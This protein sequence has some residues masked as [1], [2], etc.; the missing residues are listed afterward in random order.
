[1]IGHVSIPEAIQMFEPDL[2]FLFND[3]QILLAQLK[4]IPSTLRT[5]VYATFDGL[6]VPPEYVLLSRV[7]KL[8][9]MSHFSKR[10]YLEGT[11]ASPESISV[12]YAPADVERFHPVTD[13]ERSAMRLDLLPAWMP[14][15]GNVFLC[16]WVGRNQWRKQL[17]IMFEVMKLLR[18]GEYLECDACFTARSLTSSGDF[19]RHCGASQSRKAQGIP[20]VYLWMHMPTGKEEGD[21][22]LEDL[23]TYYG[24]FPGRDLYYT[25]GCDRRTHIPCEQMPQLYQIWDCLLFLSGG[26]GFGVPAWEAACCGIPVVFSDYSSHAEFLSEGHAGLPVKGIL[27]PEMRSSIMRYVSDVYMAVD[28]VRSLMKNRAASGAL[29]LNGRRY[30]ERFNLNAIVNQW[31]SIFQDVSKL[32]LSH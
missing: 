6:P 7:H 9:T 14:R 19:C 25:L 22:M 31:H 11:G 20:N 29:G 8:V 12:V 13:D 10:A 21:W 24:I 27:Q 32:S 4:Y 2:V 23:E 18:Y 1:M 26:E 30:A 17:W 5:I 16:G 28:S 15:D 3:P